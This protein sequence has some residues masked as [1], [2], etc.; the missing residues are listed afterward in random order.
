MAR[1]GSGGLRRHREGGL[2]TQGELWFDGET[3]V[4][5]RDSDRLGAQ[6]RRVREFMADGAW[7]TLEQI[8]VATNSPPASVS[9]RLR[10][11]R[12]PRFGGHLVERRYLRRG[13]FEYRLTCA[14]PETKK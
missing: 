4:H 7:R 10:D 5:E 9:A 3:Y 8:A 6:L 2:V 1:G 14:E 13:L 11:M 12:K